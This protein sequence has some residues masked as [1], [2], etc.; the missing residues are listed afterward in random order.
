MAKRE[1]ES[2]KRKKEKVGEWDSKKERNSE[3]QSKRKTSDIK[4]WC[5]DEDKC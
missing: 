4:Q 1:E 3:G 2:E 5:T